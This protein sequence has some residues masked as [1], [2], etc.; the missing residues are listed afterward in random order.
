MTEQ[1]KMTAFAQ[2]ALATSELVN[3]KFAQTK[4]AGTVIRGVRVVPPEGESTQGGKKARESINL[5]PTDGDG[6]RTLTCGFLDVGLRAAEL[7]SHAALD[8]IHQQR[9]QRPLDIPKREYEAFLSEL[10][11]L[12]SAEGFVLKTVDAEVQSQRSAATA[13]KK[14]GSPV[15]PIVIGAVVAVGLVVGVAVWLLG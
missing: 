3:T 9:F 5:V 15:V 13:P 1:Q 2:A 6:S 10:T 14:E 11:A 12:L 4:L 7:R 8:V